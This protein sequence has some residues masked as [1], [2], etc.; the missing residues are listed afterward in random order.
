VKELAL[1]ESDLEKRVERFLS[2]GRCT[3]RVAATH[4]DELSKS[5]DQP[6]IDFPGL[7]SWLKI[8][9]DPVR[10]QILFLLREQELCACELELVLE[11]SQ[12]TVSYHLQKLRK[13]G[14]VD[15]VREGR[16][17]LI[18]AREPMIYEWLD[19]AAAFSKERG[20]L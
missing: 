16:W 18:R 14:L 2:E 4:K 20:K 10:L 9:A 19:Q 5:L 6:T 13:V 3:C 15:L 12:P 11:I 17:T 8:L 7:S 1:S